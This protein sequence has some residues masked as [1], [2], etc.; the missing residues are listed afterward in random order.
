MGRPLGFGGFVGFRVYRMV[1]CSFLALPIGPTV[2]PIFGL[3]CRILN[4]NPKKEL[5]WSLWVMCDFIGKS[6]SSAPCS[7]GLSSPT[8]N[9]KPWSPS[10]EPDVDYLIE[11]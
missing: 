9:P 11:F 2:V 4:M 3:P 6:S 7:L 8:L 10:L 1:A 5:L